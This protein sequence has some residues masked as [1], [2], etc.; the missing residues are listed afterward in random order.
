[1]TVVLTDNVTFQAL[2]SAKLDTYNKNHAG[3][4]YKTG[5]SVKF[6]HKKQ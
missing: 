2:K 4:S 3:T 6:C 5:S 1:L